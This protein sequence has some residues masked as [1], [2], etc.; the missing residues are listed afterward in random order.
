MT[1]IPVLGSQELLDVLENTDKDGRTITGEHIRMKGA[2][3]PSI[4]H[5]AARDGVSVFELYRRLYRGQA[6]TFDFTC[7]GR[8]CGFKYNPDLSVR[9]NR[10]GEFT[11]VIRFS[12]GGEEDPDPDIDDDWAPE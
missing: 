10:G 3:T 6:I 5:A 9:S 12:K 1:Y 7:G 4:R 2:P 11:R 8:A